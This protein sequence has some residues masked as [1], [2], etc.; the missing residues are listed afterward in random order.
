MAHEGHLTAESFHGATGVLGC[1]LQQG[2]RSLVIRGRGLLVFCF[3]AVHLLNLVQHAAGLDGGVHIHHAS[4]VLG[5]AAG[6]Y[7]V[8]CQYGY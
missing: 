2:K 6:L 1:G 8:P 3:P 5:P 7:Q 4:V